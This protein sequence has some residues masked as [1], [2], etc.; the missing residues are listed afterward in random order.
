[1]AITLYPAIGEMNSATMKVRLPSSAAL[2]AA[3]FYSP[4]IAS[5]KSNTYTIFSMTI[6]T[7]SIVTL[8]QSLLS[9][10]N[11]MYT[12]K[13]VAAMARIESIAWSNS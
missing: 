9:G 1:M 8:N 11:I 6:T 10:S 4:L 12:M 7:M 2:S 13:G 5:S 3:R